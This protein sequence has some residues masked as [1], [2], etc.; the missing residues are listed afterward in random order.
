MG[1]QKAE[2]WIRCNYC[3]IEHRIEIELIELVEGK[4]IIIRVQDNSGTYVTGSIIEQ[5][6]E[7]K[8]E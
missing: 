7:P 6:E 8:R 5:D 3:G 2:A 4:G 1:R